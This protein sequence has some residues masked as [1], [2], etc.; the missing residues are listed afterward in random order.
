MLSIIVSSYQPHFYQQLEKNIAETCGVPYELIKI[1]NPGTMSIT[2]AYNIGSKRAK[3]PYCLFL[4]EDVIF[5]TSQWGETLLKHLSISNV[6]VIGIAGSSYVPKA[7]TGWYMPKSSYNFYHFIQNDKTQKHPE[8]K[9]N[10]PENKSMQKVFAVDGVFMA[11]N[12]NNID[13]TLFNEKVEGYHGY[14]LEMSLR[15]S[16]YL[17]NYIIDD[18]LI[19]HFSKGNI[20]KQWL[21]NNINIRKKMRCFQYQKQDDIEVEIQAFEDFISRYLR[22]E[23]VSLKNIMKVY[24][25]YPFKLLNFS[26]HLKILKLTFNFIRYRKDLNKNI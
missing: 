5:H 9:K 26:Q 11:I 10:F 6:G 20:D 17:Q 22:S 13:G 18:I 12:K 19:E 15:L 4:H 2:Q 25:F 3:S 16:L 14:D 1:D 8:L 7:P 21:F 23:K 24:Q